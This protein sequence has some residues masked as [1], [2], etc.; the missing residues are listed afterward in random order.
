M[1]KPQQY[2][3]AV[4]LKGVDFNG[5]I[6]EDVMQQI[7]DISSIPL[8]FTDAVGSDS[9]DNPYTEW[10]TDKLGD[11]T[12][13]G[14]VIDGS[15][16]D[17]NDAALG[18]RLGN[19]CGILTKE[20]QV[21]H[22]SQSVDT[23]GRGDELA[24]Q[25]MMRQKEL[26]RNVEANA[27]GIQGS[28][29]DDGA[30]KP[31]IPAGLAAMVTKHP[32]ASTGT[33]GVFAAG[34]WSAWTPGAGQGLTETLVRD[35]CQAAWE[36][37]ADPSLLMSVPSVIRAL[38]E[39]MFTSSARIA[40]LNRDEQGTDATALGTV[41]VFITDFGVTLE[42]VPNRLQQTYN[43]SAAK[44]VASVFLLDPAYARMSFL[45]GYRV[46]P[47]A[48]TGLSDKRLMAVDFTVKV[49]N[50]DAHR[51]IPDVDPTIAVVH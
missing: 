27:L 46:E 48:K 49:L 50:P 3:Q 9:A 45:E 12:L 21:S 2:T 51:V 40:T 24:Y 20:V 33:G 43:D 38:S 41:N 11:P 7:W 14:W 10:T 34:A 1:A 5:L 30:T 26:R 17:Q 31:G 37:G 44:K 28:Q 18:K 35:A 42:F 39:Y 13:G 47:L 32:G 25:V 15:D 6:N 36:D 4:D 19:H 29:A 22:R 8:P 16:H 23:I